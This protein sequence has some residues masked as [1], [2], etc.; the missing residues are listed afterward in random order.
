MDAATGLLY[1]GNGQYYDPATGRFLT[2]STKPNQDNPYTPFDPMGALFAPLGLMA[3]VYGRRKKGSKWA[4]LLVILSFAVVTGM[5]L[6]ACGNDNPPVGEFTA[7][8]TFNPVTGTATGTLTTSGGTFT[9][10]VVGTPGA[11]LA[12]PSLTCTQT[13]TPTS[14][15]WESQYGQAIARAAKE[16]FSNRDSYYVWGAL[17]TDEAYT[18]PP[19]AETPADGF[20]WNYA[21]NVKERT[22]GDIPVVCADIISISYK[23]AGLELSASYPEWIASGQYS[24]NP[25]RNVPA[26]LTLLTIQNDWHPPKISDSS[27]FFELGDMVISQAIGHSAVITEING[28]RNDASQVFV[29][30]ASY[31]SDPGHITRMSLAEWSGNAGWYGHP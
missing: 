10:T 2:R 19:P 4:V 21:V 30:Q 5:T 22:E 31:T 9:G 3:L 25:E 27:P 8:G 28:A 11:P 20:V 15:P 17:H 29:V 26:L 12:T 14:T 1:V 7:T 16:I 18:N 23:N 24:S 13:P 6:S